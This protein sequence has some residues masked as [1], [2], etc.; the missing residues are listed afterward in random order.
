MS[1]LGTLRGSQ[2]PNSSVELLKG[3]FVPA[4]LRRRRSGLGRERV[5]SMTPESRYPVTLVHAG[6]NLHLADPLNRD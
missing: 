6:G 3:C 4:N 1:S 5:L 2:P